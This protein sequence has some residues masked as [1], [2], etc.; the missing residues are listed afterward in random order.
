[1]ID[2]WVF[3]FLICLI[4]PDDWVDCNLLI[5]LSFHKR[6]TLLGA[7]PKPQFKSCL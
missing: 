4:T 7:G 3:T 1:M 2:I 5:G 6:K